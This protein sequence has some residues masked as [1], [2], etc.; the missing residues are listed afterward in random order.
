MKIG[1]ISDT[2]G[3][4]HPRIAEIF[5]GVE[6]ILHAGD[7]GNMAILERLECIAPVYAV[8]GNC[9]YDTGLA[10]LPRERVVEHGDLRL[11]ILHGDQLPYDDLPSAAARFFEKYEVH[12]IVYGHTHQPLHSLVDKTV[13][14]NPG[15]IRCYSGATC[16]TVAI[17][18][19]HSS[20][21][22]LAVTFY[23]LA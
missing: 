9:D 6:M 11:G 20:P 7:V 5:A 19:A 16:P 14:V 8:R 23:S 18:Q 4:W 17:M 10:S 13:V 21:L 1:L 15:A 22:S 12:A 3:L 2:H